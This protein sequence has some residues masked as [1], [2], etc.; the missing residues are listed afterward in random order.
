MSYGFLAAVPLQKLDNQL[1][2]HEKLLHMYIERGG[3]YS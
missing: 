2:M 3:K 1:Y